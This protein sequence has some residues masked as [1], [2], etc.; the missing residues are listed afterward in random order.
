MPI[1]RILGLDT[2]NYT[3]SAAAYTPR[4][5]EMLQAKKLLPVKTGELGLRQS[6]ALFHH[7]KQL[8]EILR[9]LF[10]IGNLRFEANLMQP[11][12]DA[13][14][15]SVRPRGAEGSYMPCFLAG[16]S[17]AESLAAIIPIRIF[18][19][20]H[21]VGHILAALYG[22]KRLDLIDETFAAFHISGGTTD[23]LICSPDGE[24]L[25]KCG[26]ISGSADLKAGQLID[27]VGVSLGLQFPCGMALEK[28]AA[29]CTENLPK[30]KIPESGED[31]CFSGAQNKCEDFKKEGKPPE[32]IALYTLLYIAEAITEMI[33]KR[34]PTGINKILF[35]GGV[36]SDKI[37][38][39]IITKRF[40]QY[41][42]IFTPPEYSAD[43]AVG[44]AVF[45]AIKTGV[46]V[47]E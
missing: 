6:D 26:R 45:A 39:G 35:C 38:C 8:P 15:V 21:Q 41:E 37:I 46:S 44:A 20:S 43:N 1:N 47:N 2:S 18:R 13:V 33:K 34:L 29:V 42:L 32:F 14:G 36:M 16:E 28:L 10:S 27:R 12:V 9:E 30:I 3:T 40:P 11:Y 25:I 4:R 22:A 5:N 17:F 19:T 23:M 7:T 31:F 24:E